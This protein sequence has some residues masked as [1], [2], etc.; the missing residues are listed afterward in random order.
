MND[1]TDWRSAVDFPLSGVV[2]ACHSGTHQDREWHGKY[3]WLHMNELV[4]KADDGR[5]LK[6]T[7]REIQVPYE[8]D[9]AKELGK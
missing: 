4:L 7:V 6:L 2:V 3:G 8:G 1:P 5:H 9:A